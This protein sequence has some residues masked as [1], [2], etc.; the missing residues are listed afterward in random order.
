M[1]GVCQAAFCG[2]AASAGVSVALHSPGSLKPTALA[3]TGPE[4]A[5]GDLRLERLRRCLQAQ[6]HVPGSQRV[7]TSLLSASI[8]RTLCQNPALRFLEQSTAQTARR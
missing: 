8:A 5:A 4:N 2:S 1:G 7:C 3:G 6:D